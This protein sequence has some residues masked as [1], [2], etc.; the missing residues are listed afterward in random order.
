VSDR[1]AFL[2]L[3]T[4]IGLTALAYE[5]CYP[6]LKPSMKI[7]QWIGCMYAVMNTCQELQRVGVDPG[8]L[9]TA[10]AANAAAV[11]AVQTKALA[12]AGEDEKKASGVKE[13][14]DIYGDL[15]SRYLPLIEVMIPVVRTIP[16]IRKEA[17]QLNLRYERQEPSAIKIF[18]KMV[19]DCL[20]GV[21]ETLNTYN[22]KHDN[23]DFESELGWEG[24]NDKVMAIMKNSDY[25]VPPTQCNAAGVPQGGY[26]DMSAFI[27]EQGFKTGKGGYQKDYPP[28]YVL[29]PDGSTLYTYRDVVYS[30][31]KAASSDLVLNIICSEQ[32]LA[33][34][35]V[36]LAMAMLNPA[37]TG[38]Q[39]HVSYDLVRLPSGRMSGRRGRYL[40]AD[41]LYEELKDVIR[42]T[43]REK[44]AAKGEAVTDEFFDS[45]THEARC[46]VH[47]G[48]RMHASDV[49]FYLQQV[50]TAA[51]K[52]A[53]LSV[54]CTVRTRYTLKETE[55]C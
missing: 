34:Q 32:D 18:R 3:H 11:E 12:A 29:R 35:K 14:I 46:I 38:R 37:M 7:D 15:R 1:A 9:E 27:A 47:G 2:A 21:Q 50:S 17:G 43:M 33:Q 55:H 49:F 53:L 51:M 10:Y 52:Y 36:S 42:T 4:Q 24:S 5:R 41:D 6:L 20:S 30:F 25:F 39:Y 16:D 13:Y 54:S 23:F 31:K 40:L 45:V 44:Y 28:L 22:V 8:E 48:G 19:T 26:L